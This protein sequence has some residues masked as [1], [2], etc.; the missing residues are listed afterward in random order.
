MKLR[1]IE[2]NDLPRL[3]ELFARQGFEYDFP[4]LRAMVGALAVEDGGAV[5]QAVLARPTVELY[6]L[7]DAEWRSPQWRMEALRQLHEAMRRD[8]RGKG[9]ADAH[10]W[11]PPEKKSFVSR[12]MRSFGW[13]RPAWTSLTRSTAPLTKS[14]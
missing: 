14:V 4:D 5:V 2:S 8:L 13:T 3:Q 9:F 1:V 10:V 12:L 6:F 7:L 11:I